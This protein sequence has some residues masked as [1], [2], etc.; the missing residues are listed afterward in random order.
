VV[1]V[2][3]LVLV[4]VP[5]DVVA[6]VVVPLV[7]VVALVDVVVLVVVAPG[8]P[9]P[10]ALITCQMPPKLR[11]PSPVAKCLPLSPANV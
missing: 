11:S 7:V 5:A 9:A 4:V 10:T 1:V 8:L 3:G 2:V 6:L